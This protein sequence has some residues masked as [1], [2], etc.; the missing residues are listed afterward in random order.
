MSLTQIKI[1]GHFS[2]I[3]P[4]TVSTGD[5]SSHMGRDYNF[6]ADAGLPCA[7]CEPTA[8]G[9]K[10]AICGPFARSDAMENSC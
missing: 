1:L 10:N 2:D 5:Q 7:L 3:P 9:R 4:I 8:V 6:D